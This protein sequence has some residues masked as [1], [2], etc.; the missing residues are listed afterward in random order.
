MTKA[1]LIEP[2]FYVLLFLTSLYEF[3]MHIIPV[4]ILDHSLC[5]IIFIHVLM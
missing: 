4:C 3:S 1:L 5:L 2:I